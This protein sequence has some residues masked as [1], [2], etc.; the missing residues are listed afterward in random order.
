MRERGRRP[1]HDRVLGA[2]HPAER[3]HTPEEVSSPVLQVVLERARTGSR[4]QARDDDHLVCLAVE[5]GGMRGAVSAGMCVLLE[6][7]GLVDAFD[8]IY[9]VSA[10]AVTGCATAL[11]RAAMGA[12]HYEDAAVRGVVRP[13][14]PLLGRPVVDFDLLF[15]DIIATRKPLLLD[16]QFSG[17]E[18]RALAV[19][20]DSLS[21]R[22]LRDFSDARDLLQAV[23]ASCALPRLGGRPPVYRGERMADG[24]LLEPIPVRTAIAEGAT[25]V[26]VLR[27][28]PAGYRSPAL[29]IA[30]E[31]LAFRD[32][33]GLA[34]LAQR[35][36]GVYNR[37]ADE[38]ERPQRA[39]PGGPQV[40]Q[41]TVPA[42][43]RV[44]R[45]LDTRAA[46]VAEAL[47]AGAAAMAGE[48]L[49]GAIDLCWQ[50]AVYCAA[51]AALPERPQEGTDLSARAT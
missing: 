35:G 21:L 31:S 45:R 50:P 3:L 2:G 16:G 42:G 15:E 4:P 47:R 18:F 13:I 43:T 23:R 32:D 34:R 51:P 41:V 10:G 40:H 7:T 39:G 17:P 24:G 26:L 11:R 33:P 27:S 49:A 20:L 14:R 8:R 19:S 25:H 1:R 46:L 9:G 38:L 48:V 28:R 44:P 22:V 12:T 29:R 37:L 6:A 30:G 36:R 5:G